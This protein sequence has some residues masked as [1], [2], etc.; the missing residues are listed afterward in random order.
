MIPNLARTIF[1]SYATDSETP[2]TERDGT[3]APSMKAPPS[4]ATNIFFRD[5]QPWSVIV[6]WM[7]LLRSMFP[8]HVR[9][10]SVGTSFEGREILG[11]RVGV[12]PDN[13]EQPSGPRRTVVITGGAHAREWI[14]TSTVSYVAYSLITAYGK[15][16][17]MTSLMEEFDFVFLPTIN[18]DGYVYSWEEDRLWRKNRQQTSLPFCRGIDLD[19]SWDYE[20]DGDSPQNNPCY[21]SYAGS[22]PFAAYETKQLS[23][24]AKN[25]TQNNGV[26][27]VGFL[28]LHSYS[29]HIYFPFSYSCLSTPPDL[30]NLEELAHGLAKAIRKTSG[31]S[32]SVGAACEGNFATS[33]DGNKK[34]FP[35]MES[36]G[37]SALDWFY[38]ELKVHYSYQIKLRDT[39][40]YGFL[41]PR[42]HIVPTGKEVYS[43]VIEFAKF[44]L[45]RHVQSEDTRPM[46]MEMLEQEEEALTAESETRHRA[47]EQAFE[48]Q[49]F[50][51]V[52]GAAEIN[53]ELKR[54]RR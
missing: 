45:Q 51:A 2:S 26:Q 15:S 30:E 52:E 49:A 54:K 14:S 13:A 41:L 23:D 48:S 4:D 3:F 18:P 33:A 17:L 43:A 16:K 32:Y 29:E 31:E 47:S 21:E 42:H 10:V 27:F 7:R 24:W 8:T 28:D 50:E 20:W 40:S 12:H 6:P 1:E 46:T 34:Y 36:G 22:E 44:Y 53:W 9:L 11:L 39:G 25:E 38:H 37:G 35:R 19:R 5:Y